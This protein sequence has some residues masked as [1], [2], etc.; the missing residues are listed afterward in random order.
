MAR[1]EIDVWNEKGMRHIFSAN[2]GRDLAQM[3]QHWSQMKKDC[4]FMFYKKK[5]NKVCVTFFSAQASG[6]FFC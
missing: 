1:L 5:H 3:S 4:N 2:S 6:E